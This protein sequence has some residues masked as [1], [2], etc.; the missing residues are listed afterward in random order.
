MVKTDVISV[1]YSLNSRCER[2]K[3]YNV[4]VAN[5]S[6]TTEEKYSLAVDI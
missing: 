5:S 2:D 1:Y 4:I 6:L 3:P